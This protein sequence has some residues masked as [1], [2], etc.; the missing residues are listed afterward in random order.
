M[1]KPTVTENFFKNINFDWLQSN[2]IPGEQTRW[3]NF[4]VLRETNQSRLKEI[5][6]SHNSTE[7][8]KKLNILW[9]KGNDSTALNE[10]NIVN[11]LNTNIK[12]LNELL[13]HRMEYGMMHLFS[14]SSYTD[15][16]DST[17]N[18]IYFGPAGLGLPDRDYFLLDSMQDK[19][20]SYKEYLQTFLSHCNIDEDY[21]TIYEFEKNVATVH[22]PKAD[23]RD[24]HKIYNLYTYDELVD[25]FPGIKW[26]S[27]FERFKLPT[28]DKIV[29]SQPLF[30]KHLSEHMVK[31]YQDS[32]MMKS[33]MNYMKYRFAK[34]VCTLIDDK[35]YNIYFDFYCKTLLGQ[36]EQKPRWKRV[37]ES[38]DGTLGEV[39][40]KVYVQKYFGEDQKNSCKKMIDEIVTTYKERIQNLDWMSDATKEKAHHKLS[41]FNVKIGYPD[42]WTDFSTLV[43][44]DSKSYYEN[45]LE[46]YK[47]SME[48]SMSKAYKPVD[49]LEWH[50][51]AH[52]VNAYYSPTM[53]EI[54]FPAGILQAPFYSINQT[55]AENLGGI[56]AVIGHEITHGF[57]DKGCMFDAEG[58][59]NNWWTEEDTKHFNERSKKME[60]LFSSFDYFGINVNGKLTLGEN[61]ADLGGVTLS[62]K[63]LE[64]L[65]CSKNGIPL[66]K[67]L[68]ENFI[69]DPHLTKNCDRLL[70]NETKCLFEQWAKV[71]RCNITDDHLKNQLLTDPHSPAELRVNGILCNLD[72]FYQS[73]DIKEGDKMYVNP[74]LRSKIW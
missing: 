13:L 34:S 48:D 52:D 51:N 62:L 46:C 71:W 64:R 14:I 63:T 68:N 2:P 73:Y 59:L 25:Q 72:E 6:E 22:L 56:G 10:M 4:M 44:Y 21:T 18:I 7:E 9:T 54:V 60:D 31:C 26:A 55:L 50:M 29:V 40:S 42:K 28:N 27:I 36:K 38:I 23:C 43:V 47:W 15:M 17:R 8:Q 57:D 1:S 65:L 35:S 53:N 32:D 19:Q 70:N 11:I 30:F 49:K 20:A 45:M 66:I 12:D 5:L 39:L 58:N 37:V 24:P 67:T 3:N 16:K 41:K 61:I 33:M 69:G 74:S